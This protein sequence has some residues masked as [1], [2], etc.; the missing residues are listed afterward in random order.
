MSHYPTDNPSKPDPHTTD[1]VTAVQYGFYERVVELID[2]DSQLATTP[3]NDNITLLHWAAIN[4]RVEIAKYLINKGAKIDAFGGALNSTPLHWAVRDGK[5]DMV[6]FLL[7]YDAQPLLEDGEGFSCIHLASIFGHSAIV[8]YLVAKGQDINLPDKSGLTPLMHAAHKVKN[9]DPT[10][11]LIRLGASVNEQNPNN[12]YTALH[13]AVSSVNTE[14]IRVLIDCGAKTNIRNAD[15]EDIYEFAA[16]SPQTR[17]LILLISQLTIANSDLPKWLQVDR[18]IRTLGTKLFPYLVLIFIA[19][20]VEL[21]LWF[22]HKGIIMLILIFLGYG[23]MMVFFDENLSRN[24]P[25]SVAQASIFCL[26]ACYLYYFLP[27]VHIISFSFIGLVICTYLSWSN[28]YLAIKSDPG[29]IQ[30]N[31]DQQNRIIIQLVEQNLF[32][33]ETY[34]TW[35][36]ARKPLRSKHC[37]QCRRCVARFDHHCPWVD[38]C[39]GDKNLRYFT[40]FVCFTPLCLFLYLHGAYLFYQNYCHIPS[41]EPWTHIFHCAP[42]VT[43][44]TSIAFLHCLW[45][46]GLGATVL[47][48][49]AAG[50]TTNERI[51]SWKYKYF[52]S[53][54][55]SPFSFGVIQNLVDL[56]NRRILCY[57][58]TNLDWTRIYTIEDFTELIPLRLRRS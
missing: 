10:Q 32:D 17:Y 6:I 22:V 28:Y 39:V 50:F 57:T 35:C 46:S 52:Q 48:Q 8:A 29:Y 18:S 49:I 43:W 42:S 41:S 45:V 38:N 58:P 30:I 56:M 1:I 11:L 21:S 40:G 2:A 20:V 54:A 13:Y 51:N 12:K 23:Y 9:R 3:V 44:F 5:L 31:R 24:L 34:C 26:Y 47:V 15:N 36:L 4:S 14:A 27:Y 7:S 55:K 37:R 16:K 19:C 33:Y 53:N 25:I